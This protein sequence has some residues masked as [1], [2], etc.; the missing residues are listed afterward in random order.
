MQ[1][2]PHLATSPV[3]LSLEGREPTDHGGAWLQGWLSLLGLKGVVARLIALGLAMRGK[4]TTL[5]CFF[6]E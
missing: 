2:P 6:P 4:P 3:N 1:S 5:H